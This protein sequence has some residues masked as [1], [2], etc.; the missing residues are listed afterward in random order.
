M[1]AAMAM[2]I[3][4]LDEM[5]LDTETTMEVLA[6]GIGAVSGFVQATALA[7]TPAPVTRCVSK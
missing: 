5:K 2:D 1:Q 4:D 6:D 3:E 7:K